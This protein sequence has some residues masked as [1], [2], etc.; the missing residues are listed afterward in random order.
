MALYFVQAPSQHCLVSLAEPLRRISRTAASSHEWKLHLR[1]VSGLCLQS[2]HADAK[3]ISDPRSE[4]SG[5]AVIGIDVPDFHRYTCTCATSQS[6]R[7]AHHMDAG[8]THAS[9]MQ[10]GRHLADNYFK[11]PIANP[12]MSTT[13]DAHAKHQSTLDILLLTVFL[14]PNKSRSY[15]TMF[16]GSGGHRKGFTS[17]A[18]RIQSSQPSDKRHPLQLD[19]P[20]RGRYGL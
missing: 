1:R 18:V 13:R 2:T 11:S 3:A 8:P 6:A 14:I 4:K 19:D 12:S 9:R 10:E 7:N 17:R 15:L 20:T 5:Q 16:Q